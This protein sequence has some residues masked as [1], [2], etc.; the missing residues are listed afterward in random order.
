MSYTI[1]RYV[2]RLL[3]VHLLP[4]LIGL[5]ALLQILDLLNS[6]D[7]IT[8]RH[9]GN[10]SSLATYAALRLP[11]IINLILPFAMLMAALLCLARLVRG[12]EII[13]LKAGGFSFYRLLLAFV[14]ATFVIGIAYFIVNDQLVPWATKTLA[15]WDAAPQPARVNSAPVWLRDGP[16]LVG[17]DGVAENGH[18]LTGVRVFERNERGILTEQIVANR[19]SFRDGHWYFQEAWRFNMTEGQN[20]AAIFAAELLWNT[21]LTPEHFANLATD[22]ATLSFK[23]LLL[24]IIRPNVGARSVYFY[25]TW[26]QHKVALP[27]SLLVM[28]LLAAPVAQGMLRQGGMATGLALGVA[29][30][31]LYFVCE[32]LMLTLGET[33]ALAP[34]VAAWA[35]PVLFGTLGAFWLLR[36]EGY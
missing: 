36:V 2:S 16:V 8:A 17:V 30:G 3:F 12:N 6:A 18:L 22:P 10:V 35:P 25:Q 26:L 29:L 24:F 34:L 19:A 1:V 23:D 13:A 31:F 28:I 5:V 32:G 9:G 7:D 27:I 33:G 4:L 14:P 15:T 20:T 11:Q 21:L